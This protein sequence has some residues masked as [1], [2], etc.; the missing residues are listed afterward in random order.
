MQPPLTTTKAQFVSIYSWEAGPGTLRKGP[1]L[2]LLLR[3][4]FWRQSVL[5]LTV[6][7]DNTRLCILCIFTKSYTGSEKC[8]ISSTLVPIV[9]H[10]CALK[11][12]LAFFFWKNYFLIANTI[13]FPPYSFLSFPTPPP[14]RSMEKKSP[15]SFCSLIPFTQALLS[16]GEVS[17]ETVSELSPCLHV[18]TFLLL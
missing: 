13:F 11:V 14:H 5:H 16:S 6:T 18:P 9:G 15:I 1:C 12:S 3:E 17:K 4:R 8:I 2:K 10:V 7:K